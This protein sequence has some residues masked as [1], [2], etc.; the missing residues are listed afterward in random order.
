MAGTFGGLLSLFNSDV[1]ENPFDLAIIGRVTAPEVTVRLDGVELGDGG[2]VSFG[3]VVQGQPRDRTFTVTNDGGAPLS[4]SPLNPSTLPAG[5]TLAANLATTILAPG[6]STAFTVRLGATVAGSFGG[7]LSLATSD[8]DENSFDL[9]LAGNVIAPEIAV[10]VDGVNAL[11]GQ[12]VDFGVTAPAQPIVRTITVRNEGTS[13]LVLTP[14]NPANVPAGFTLVFNLGTT[15]LSP[16]QSTSFSLRLEAAAFGT[17]GGSL[18]LLN[19]DADEGPFE[20][21]LAG[22]VAFAGN[23]RA[24]ERRSARG[25]AS[26]EFRRHGPGSTRDARLCGRQRGIRPPAIDAA[27]PRQHPRGLYARFQ[28][29]LGDSRAGPVHRVHAAARRAGGGSF[30]GTIALANSDAD[31]NP[32]DLTVTASV[33]APEIAV[34]LAGN[35]L[36]SGAILDFGTRP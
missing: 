10:E 30:G 22:R 8:P 7:V 13:L 1:D 29:W 9:L 24:A 2:F 35:G 11:D 14:I 34:E 31:E 6:Q 15:T 20:L 19:N 3:D 36:S 17:F 33:S 21:V 12:T 28:H 18:S 16:G 23:Q 32:F 4:L 25:W 27:R 26:T 5:F